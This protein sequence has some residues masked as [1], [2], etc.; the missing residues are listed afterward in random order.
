M[1]YHFINECNLRE[2]GIRDR[3]GVRQEV[4]EGG[5]GYCCSV[6]KNFHLSGQL[7]EREEDSGY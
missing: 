1:C 3:R 7:R 4:R 2:T 5:H 6:D